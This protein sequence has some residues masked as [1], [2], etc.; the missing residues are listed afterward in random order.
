MTLDQLHAIERLSTR[1]HAILA[2]A[3]S[4]SRTRLPSPREEALRTLSRITGR[5]EA[6]SIRLRLYLDAAEGKR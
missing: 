3:L 4:T 1:L 6:D 5:L 2:D